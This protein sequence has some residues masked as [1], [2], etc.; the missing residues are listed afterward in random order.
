MTEP[1][2]NGQEVAPE[3]VPPVAPEGAPADAAEPDFE[4]GEREYALILD[5]DGFEGPLD[6]L[7]T[8]TR[9][10]KV[11][12]SKISILELAEQYLAFITRARELKL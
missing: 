12:L 1:T 4:S 9:N 7:L 3:K 8:L 6:V 10:Q 11:D 5:L 2:E